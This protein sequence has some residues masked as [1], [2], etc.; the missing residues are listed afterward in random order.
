MAKNTK[1]KVFAT[2]ASVA[3]VAS[4]VVPAAVA[5]AD[6]N[7]FN[8][9]PSWAT[10][11][12]QYLADNGYVQGDQNGNF[13]P[14]KSISRAEAA[15]IFTNVLGLSTS[16]TETFSDVNGEW[17]A[18]AAIATSNTTPK[19]FKGDGAG[20]FLPNKTLTRQEAAVAIVA[21]YGLTGEAS[22]DFDDTADIASWA[23]DA[24]EAA[25]ANGIINGRGQDGSLFA[26]KADISKAEFAV[27]IKRAIDATSEAAVVGVSATNLK[28]IVVSFNT[29]LDKDT[30]EDLT[31]YTLTTL[32]GA[33]LTGGDA[34]LQADGKSVLLTLG[35]EA[36][37]QDSVKVTVDGVLAANGVAVEET[38]KS[39]SF[40]DTKAPVAQSVKVTGPRT[41]EVAFSEPLQN[42]PTTFKLDNGTYY[43]AVT[44]FTPGDKKVTLSLGTTLTEDTHS[45]TVSGGDDYAE[46]KVAETT[47]NFDYQKDVVAPTVS[48]SKATETKV[49]VKFSEPVAATGLNADVTAYYGYNKSASYKGTLAAV[50]AVGG[51]SDT[52]TV[53][54]STPIPEG[55][56]TLYLNTKADK[57]Q[58]A[59]G[60]DVVSTQLGFSVVTDTVKPTVLSVSAEAD[61]EL[62][63]KFSEEVVEADAENK[64]YYTLKDANGDV[65]KT[66]SFADVDNNGHLNANATVSYNA[67][68]KEATIN[69]TNSLPGGTYYLTVEKVRDNAFVKN[70]MESA[71]YAFNVTD[72]SAPSVSSAVVN[73][74]GSKIRVSFNEPMSTEGLTDVSNYRLIVD[75]SS[76]V[77]L[78]DDSTVSIVN[79]KTVEISLG[80]ADS[81]ID[82]AST[83]KIQVS[84]KLKD[85]TGNAIGGFFAEQAISADA[86]ALVDNSAAAV[87]AKTIQFEVDKELSGIDVDQFTAVA[88]A[89]DTT[90]A[91]VANVY[92][93]ND[94]GKSTVT[95]VLD[96][97]LETDLTGF[98]SLTIAAGG[99]TNVFGTDNGTN[100]V[101]NT[102]GVSALAD[103]VAPKVESVDTASTSTI[104]VTFSEAINADTVSKYTFGVEGNTVTGISWAGNVLT[105][106][107]DDAIQTGDTP[108]VTQL[109]DLED[110]QGNVLEAG[111]SV[112]STDDGVVPAISSVVIGGTADDAVTAQDTI[113]ITF[114]EATDKPTLNNASFNTS[115]K[116]LD[117][118]NNGS[119]TW[120]SEGTVLTIVLGDTPTITA[121]DTIAFAAVDTVEDASGNDFG[122]GTVYTVPTLAGSDW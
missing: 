10:D 64:T 79:S 92:Y 104:D 55:S 48:V 110:S 21:A 117:L 56:H 19:I 65:I 6:L 2:T 45:V 62:L 67:T 89:A 108:A 27:M 9:V 94:S 42:V 57:L 112:A 4:A 106:T 121:A 122:T 22:L 50:D 73:S 85:A 12:V 120:N 16:G 98:T 30:A 105:L 34:E 81:N 29:Q 53:T 88:T 78:P 96:K 107:L 69:F 33:S 113:T 82:G 46:F 49:T 31:N 3:M 91:S 58:D 97:A 28:E 93:T 35:T 11:A 39:V 26:P 63:V 18:D 41:L 99:L 8:T 51:Y 15:E 87:N 13:N 20:H 84:G 76:S 61:D 102:A 25:V 83:D 5:A 101:V 1:T 37:Q 80:T 90:A 59:W 7:D 70:T 119:A 38:S 71:T 116:T 95:V 60:N 66:A 86:I 14:G 75:N 23:T 17:F 111:S 44:N 77:A 100:I 40:F 74:D 52:Y 36:D 103:E 32:G 24:A 72:S 68:D 109:L 47:L 43:A 114:T 54:F 115:T 118:A